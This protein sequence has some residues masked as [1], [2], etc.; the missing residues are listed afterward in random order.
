[1]L[2]GRKV[3]FHLIAQAF[4]NMGI[5]KDRLANAGLSP[6]FLGFRPAYRVLEPARSDRSSSE[7]R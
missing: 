4:V 3:L 2:E 7:T 5:G 6:G 1:M